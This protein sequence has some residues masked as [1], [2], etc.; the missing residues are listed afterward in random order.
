MPASPSPAPSGP[1]R[2]A[3]GPGSAGSLFTAGAQNAHLD[4]L[5]RSQADRARAYAADADHL[6]GWLDLVQADAGFDLDLMAMELAP[7]LRV[8]QRAAS[9]LLEDAWRLRER[10][11]VLLALLADA[12]IWLPQAQVILR[13]TVGCS[14]AVCAAVQSRLLDPDAKTGLARSAHQP[15][16]ELRRAVR[17][18][19][20]AAEADLEPETTEQ[21][22]RDAADRRDVRLSPNGDG[23]VSLWALLTV[24]QALAHA[25]DLD[26]LCTQVA[27]DDLA[28]GIA[29]T[30]GQRRADILAMLPGIAL[31]GWDRTQ[32]STG[33]G[34]GTGPG[35]GAG[36]GDKTG[37][38][39][40]PTGPTSPSSPSSPTGTT[41]PGGPGG[42][43]SAGCG[44]GCGGGFGPESFPAGGP[45]PS[46]EMIIHVPMATALGLSGEPGEILGHSLVS[47]ASIRRL[48]PDATLRRLIV[49]AQTGQPLH[50]DPRRV[51]PGSPGRTARRRPPDQPSRDPEAGT[52]TAPGPDPGPEPP[53][54]P[55]PDLGPSPDPGLSPA[56]GPSPAPDPDRGAGAGR[57]APAD[58]TGVLG[59]LRGWLGLTPKGEPAV[60]GPVLT[61]TPGGTLRPLTP[62]PARP[63]PARPDSAGPDAAGPDA[64]GPDPAGPDRAR[65]NAGG[66]GAGGAHRA[67]TGV[68]ERP[69][70]AAA[71]P[72]RRAGP[73]P[74]PA[75]PDLHR[76]RL[77]GQ[78]RPVR[79]GPPAASRTR[80]APA[81]PDQREQPRTQEPTLPPRQ[82][83]APRQPPPLDL[84]T[85][86]RRQYH[87]DEPA[88]ACSR[89]GRLLG[90]TSQP[91]PE[92]TSSAGGRREQR[93]PHQP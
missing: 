22:E 14:P 16:A 60:T 32:T 24:E 61:G 51:T 15:P 13:E 37:S 53:A 65:P 74:A 27:L 56:P 12:R 4:A 40:G 10:L 7:A 38:P 71:R 66:P 42:P 5:E 67:R 77:L 21:R 57:R 29:R 81:R 28:A 75:R 83:P 45:A 63:N 54:G 91:D 52:V 87:L 62:D 2:D 82:D 46:V 18:A 25:R 36:T 33:A 72:Q 44:G 89:P 30:A 19:V 70:R 1:S 6:A 20:L 9:G 78:R 64:A 43:G 39:T 23:T 58:P 31:R 8:G 50:L 34:P 49:D 48:L 76:T 41:G 35:A 69:A 3:G 11:P 26:A 86:L 85:Q 93:R 55:D 79:P 47:A 88:R 68:A 17:R 73:V 80:R 92:T 59:V 90:R 84:P